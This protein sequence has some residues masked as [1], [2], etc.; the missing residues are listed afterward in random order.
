MLVIL[1]VL[2][3]FTGVGVG[4]PTWVVI[5]ELQNRRTI[6]PIRVERAKHPCWYWLCVLSHVLLL[7]FMTLV[8]GALLLLWLVS[9]AK[10]S[11]D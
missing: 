2:L 9:Q 7:A 4:G 10:M 1:G 8:C 6:P 11:G 5:L 3:L